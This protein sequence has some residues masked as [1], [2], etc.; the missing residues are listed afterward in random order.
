VQLIQVDPFDLQ[1]AQAH[2][3]T[4]DQIAGASHVLGFGRALAG[5]A[6]LGGN[7]QTLGIWVK[8]FCDQ[9]LGDLRTVGVG[10]V[11]QVDAEF[12]GAAQHPAGCGGIG[13]F[14]P[15]ALAHKAHS[16]V[17]EPVN[18]QIAA[19][20]EGQTHRRRGGCHSSFDA[21][22]RP[23]WRVRWGTVDPKFAYG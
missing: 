19:D 20:R 5:D 10:G 17:A 2:L 21:T 4:L 23:A 12:N 18:G 1:A 11:D 3:D 15:R 14:A 16:S 13:R 8:S 22:L 6:T 7:D 9:P